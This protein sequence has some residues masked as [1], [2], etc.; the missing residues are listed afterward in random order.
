METKELLAKVRRVEIKTRRL[1]DHLFSGQ[2][3]ASF[4]GRG[5]TFSEVRPYQ[6]GDDIRTIDWNVTAKLREPY[7]KVFEEERELTLM[8][9]VDLSGS[10]ELGSRGKTKRELLTEVAATLAFSA[11]QNQD[12]VGALFF[13]DRIEAYLPPKKGRGAALRIIRELLERQPAGQGTNLT[14]ALEHLSAVQKKKCIAFVLSDFLDGNYRSALKV[15]ARKHDVNALRLE[16]PIDKPLPEVGL[17]P[18]LDPETGHWQ[19]VDTSSKAVQEQ[20]HAA[21]SKHLNYFKQSITQSGAGAVALPTNKDYIPS[22]LHY[23]KSKAA[24]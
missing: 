4:K 19:W 24:R 9:L 10:L 23:F 17:L 21:Y 8:L 15:A 5:M 20:A 2:Y 3:H 7:I 6:F 14:L 1:S 18:I 13:T 22:L 12:K 16:D 11:L